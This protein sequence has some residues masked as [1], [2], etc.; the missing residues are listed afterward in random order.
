MF[1]RPWVQVRVNDAA[2]TDEVIIDPEA[3][4]KEVKVKRHAHDEYVLPAPGVSKTPATSTETMRW[5][6]RA[7]PDSLAASYD[8]L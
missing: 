2:R 8:S 5:D 3:E 7:L 6:A 1:T 4:V